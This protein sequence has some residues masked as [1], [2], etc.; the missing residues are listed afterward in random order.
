M[1]PC[2]E[3][4]IYYL[5]ANIIKVFGIM[6]KWSSKL[7]VISNLSNSVEVILVQMHYAF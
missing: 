7:F 5:K 4:E 2:M 6:G 1:V 3:K